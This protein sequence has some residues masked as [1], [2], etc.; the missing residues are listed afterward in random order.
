MSQNILRCPSSFY[1]IFFYLRPTHF[2]LKIILANESQLYQRRLGG[3]TSSFESDVRVVRQDNA[4]IN[5][6]LPDKNGTIFA[7]QNIKGNVYFN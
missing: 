4:R 6:F 7:R 1:Q 3:G 5:S 2:V